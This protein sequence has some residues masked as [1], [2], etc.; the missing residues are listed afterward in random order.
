MSSHTWSAR[1]DPGLQ[2]ER[3]TLAWE[4]TVLAYLGVTCLMIRWATHDRPIVVWPVIISALAV[5]GAR[6]SLGRSHRRTLSGVETVTGSDC[7]PLIHL[8]GG[9]TVLLGF[10]GLVVLLT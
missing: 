7:L 3:T 8:L 6:I 1:T 2:P 9:A 10:S 5:L 4:R